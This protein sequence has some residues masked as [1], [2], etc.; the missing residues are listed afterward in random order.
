MTS[1]HD[2]LR[3]RYGEL[4]RARLWLAA[5]V[6]DPR[7]RAEVAAGFD[8]PAIE[9]WAVGLFNPPARSEEAA[10]ALGW[11]AGVRALAAGA[12]LA[13]PWFERERPGDPRPRRLLE[14][15]ERSVVARWQG[16]DEAVEAQAA[17]SAATSNALLAAADAAAV[18][19]ER[20]L[21]D[22][23]S[24]FLEEAPR[25]GPDRLHLGC[26]VEEG[27][28]VLADA[29]V[30]AAW[31]RGTLADR[32]ILALDDEGVAQAELPGAPAPHDVSRAARALGATERRVALGGAFGAFVDVFAFP[33]L[34]PARDVESTERLERAWWAASAVVAGECATGLYRAARALGTPRRLGSMEGERP[35][36]TGPEVRVAVRDALVPWLLEAPAPAG[37]PYASA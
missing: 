14:A 21:E 35:K 1:L 22:E 26:V 37:A 2:E 24:T 33:R 6:G 30:L 11:E 13:L 10:R 23:V 4:A 28:E 9:L 31:L 8:E 19:L 17:L 12:G 7:A 18:F 16:G 29:A 34:R 27:S 20:T 3:A 15:I 25:G 5:H 36:V 32:N